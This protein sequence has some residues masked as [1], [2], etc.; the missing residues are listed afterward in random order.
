MRRTSESRSSLI[1][2]VN[3]AEMIGVSVE[4]IYRWSRESRGPVPT[5]IGRSLRYR[6]EDVDAWL[7]S[8]R[9]VED[10]ERVE[11]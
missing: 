11:G 6:M 4:T 2:A 7:E 10:G 3:L 1:G 8:S 9:G 5:R